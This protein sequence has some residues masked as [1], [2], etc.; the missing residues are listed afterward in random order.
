MELG[1]KSFDDHKNID[2]A[3]NYIR[4]IWKISV[5]DQEPMLFVCVVQSGVKSM[6]E[7]H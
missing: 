2:F 6:A 7:D 1:R 5:E 3:C 4:I